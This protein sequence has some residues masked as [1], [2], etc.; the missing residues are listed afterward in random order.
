MQKSSR[1]LKVP[2][3]LRGDYH[4]LNKDGKAVWEPGLPATVTSRRI[5]KPA[6]VEPSDEAP[7]QCDLKK[8]LSLPA[9]TRGEWLEKALK[10]IPSGRCKVQDVFNI[11]TNP[12][13][14]SGVPDKIGRRMLNMV[15]EFS[16]NFSDKQ[17]ITLVSKCKLAERFST[18]L[19]S[20]G[21]DEDDD[22]DEDDGDAQAP[23]E[24]A[25]P[26][27][28]QRRSPD[29]SRDRSG[30]SSSSGDRRRELIVRPAP[31]APVV[32]E[33]GS[34]AASSSSMGRPQNAEEKIRLELTSHER[35]QKQEEERRKIEAD[36]KALMNTVQEARERERKAKLG[37]AF[38]VGGDDDDEDTTR[39]QLA[40]TMLKPDRHR[41][42]DKGF[43]D[44]QPLALVAR[45]LPSTGSGQDPRFVEAMGGDKLLAEAH[46][47]LKSAAGSGR[48]GALPPTS[49]SPSRER[50]RRRSR[51]RS[52]GLRQSRD[53]QRTHATRNTGSY[54][55]PTPDGR[56]RGQARAARKAKMIASL[57]GIR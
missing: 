40:K 23:A 24:D 10:G 51:S 22:G 12:K 45:P 14:A 13:F 54:R 37:S 7:L 57:M 52:R 15:R 18:S 3:H 4:T 38:L 48:L 2:S 50:R 33:A 34:S 27:R 55:S 11:V 19:N 25:F 53:R 44:I 16:E 41:T 39:L 49:R 35:H 56:A 9:V 1:A 32:T 30:D 46:K 29:R 20:G 26:T 21:D 36:R 5:H 47:I 42:E 28:R 17:R 6:R 43:S 31:P 8:T